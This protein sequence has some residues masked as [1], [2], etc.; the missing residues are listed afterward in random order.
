MRRLEKLAFTQWAIAY[1]QNPIAFPSS[2]P[3]Q[4]LAIKIDSLMSDGKWRT[5]T[6][7]AG[8][9]QVFLTTVQGVMWSIKDDW[10]YQAIPSKNKGYRK[11]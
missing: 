10:G 8:K 11:L 2:K 9:L 6:A 1:R 3:S 7:I 5:A 4:A